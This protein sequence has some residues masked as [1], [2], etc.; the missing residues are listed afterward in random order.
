MRKGAEGVQSPVAYM[1]GTRDIGGQLLG[2]LRSGMSYS[3]AAS[4]EQMWGNARFVR[5]TEAGLRD[6]AA[7]DAYSH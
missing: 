4:T 6:A 2:G 7:R 5:Q 1:G 3:D